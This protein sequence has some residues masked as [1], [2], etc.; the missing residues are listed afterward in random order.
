MAD[1]GTPINFQ[2][3]VPRSR[4]EVINSVMMMASSQGTVAS[5]NQS[6][7]SITR[8]YI[9]MWAIIVAIVGF[10]VAFLGLLAL[11]VKTTEVC[12]IQFSDVQGGTLV[13]V[14]GI[15][16][17]QLQAMLASSLR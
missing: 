12:T 16:S 13:Q 4:P 15:G 5:D 1:A 6:Y 10:F 7:I 11:L 17:P 3:V 14:S 2:T 9:P 8:K